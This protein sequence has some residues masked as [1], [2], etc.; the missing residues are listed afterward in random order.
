MAN[1]G[2]DDG[3]TKLGTKGFFCS[4]TLAIHFKTLFSTVAQSEIFDGENKF[5][6]S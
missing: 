2:S 6:H 5:I 1:Y 3:W 4:G